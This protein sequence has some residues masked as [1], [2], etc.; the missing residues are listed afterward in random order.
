M[1]YDPE[2]PDKKYLWKTQTFKA[3]PYTG[4]M[5]HKIFHK[6][7]IWLPEVEEDL[8]VAEAEIEEDEDFDEDG[9]DEEEDQDSEE[10]TEL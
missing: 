6:N 8:E 9:K 10:K 1:K 2:T 7:D 3:K 4:P 5:F